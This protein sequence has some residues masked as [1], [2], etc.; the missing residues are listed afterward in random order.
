LLAN[1]QES[2]GRV[3]CYSQRMNTFAEFWPFYLRE[4]AR[5]QTRMLHVAGTSLSVLL[6]ASAAALR[7]GWLVLVALVCGY[8]FAWVGHYFVEHNRPATFKYP[9]WSFAADWKMWALTLTGRLAPELE[10]AGVQR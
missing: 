8:A 2:A 9:F 7:S 10:R 4:H 5:P 3:D 6:L 1:W